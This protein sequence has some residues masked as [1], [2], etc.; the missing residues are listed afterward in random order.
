M[1]QEEGEFG[2]V[3]R[4]ADAIDA[5][6]G[7]YVGAGWSGE[8]VEAGGVGGEVDGAEEVEGGGWSEDFPEGGFHGGADGG[9]DA[10]KMG[11]ADG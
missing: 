2:E 6:D 5:D 3:G 8:G 10:W 1:E 7:D 9:F 4:F 11:L